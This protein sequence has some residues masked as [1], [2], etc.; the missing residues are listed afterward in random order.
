VAREIWGWF[1]V[2]PAAIRDPTTGEIHPV[3]LSKDEAA[4]HG[5]EVRRLIVHDEEGLL[6]VQPAEIAGTTELDSDD[7]CVVFNAPDSADWLL[8]RKRDGAKA[9]IRRAPY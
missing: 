2:A 7:E 9:R 3:R 4:T 8:I 5:I 6:E 1:D